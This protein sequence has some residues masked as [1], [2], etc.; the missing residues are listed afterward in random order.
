MILCTADSLPRLCHSLWGEHGHRDA[1]FST[2][3]P[4]L[5]RA[6]L[7]QEPHSCAASRAQLTGTSSIHPSIPLF[8]LRDLLGS[9]CC[10]VLGR[11]GCSARHCSCKA[12]GQDSFAGHQWPAVWQSLT[13]ELLLAAGGEIERKGETT[14][15]CHDGGLWWL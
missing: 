9:G 8:S 4:S 2:C 7:M 10:A 13:A 6:W 3:L 15:F 12:P 1:A 5:H 11:R 14:S